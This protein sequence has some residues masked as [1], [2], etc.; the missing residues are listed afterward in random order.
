[1][2]LF[3]YMGM[4]SDRTLGWEGMYTIHPQE[5]MDGEA[6]ACGIVRLNSQ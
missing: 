5:R 4:E 6:Y 1:V 2:S 3:T